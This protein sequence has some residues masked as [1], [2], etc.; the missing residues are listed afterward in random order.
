VAAAPES[1]DVEAILAVYLDPDEA[2]ERIG[3][4]ADN[5]GNT[6]STASFAPSSAE[7]EPLTNR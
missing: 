5:A 7:W 3:L 2:L 4:S 1:R 6:W